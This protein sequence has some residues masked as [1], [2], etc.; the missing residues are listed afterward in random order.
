MSIFNINTK[1][2]PTVF[3]IT[4]WKA[5]SQWVKQVLRCIA[6]NRI[7]E[8][9]LHEAHFYHDPIINGKIYPGVYVTKK[10]FESVKV[11]QNHLKF[12]IIRDLRDTLIS[13]YFST[14]YSHP[15]IADAIQKRRECLQS[16]DIEQGLKYTLHEQLKDCAVIVNSWANSKELIMKYEDLLEDE[17]SQFSKILEHCKIVVPK[18]ILLHAISSNS[19]EK[20]S[21]GRKRG[22]EDIKSH[23]RKGVSGDWKNYFSDSLKNEFKE[24][25]GELLIKTGYEKDM[26][27]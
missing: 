2:L 21:G 5:G 14:K 11:P 9:K 24:L 7:V 26:S 1:S 3:H 25:Y 18:E 13:F 19:F 20:K 16:I 10:G 17:L 22:Q 8:Q 4:H 12:I 23:F 6:P 27:W 15:V